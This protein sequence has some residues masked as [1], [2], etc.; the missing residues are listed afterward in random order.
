MNFTLSF[1]LR[2]NTPVISQ[3]LLLSPVSTVV[4]PAWSVFAD[5]PNPIQ[6]GSRDAFSRIMS[7]CL[8]RSVED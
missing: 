5:R 6:E 7:R 3:H 4:K 1:L 8:A 2:S